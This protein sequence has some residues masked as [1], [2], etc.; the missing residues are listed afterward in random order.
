MSRCAL[1]LTITST[2][3]VLFL[4]IALKELREAERGVISDNYVYF[5]LHTCKEARVY[6]TYNVPWIKGR[7]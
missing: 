7:K 6:I 3:T 2:A 5:T 1:H 4:E